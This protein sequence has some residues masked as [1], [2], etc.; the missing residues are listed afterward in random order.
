MNSLVPVPCPAPPRNFV[1]IRSQLFQLSDGETDR[2]PI[3][4]THRTENITSFGGGNNKTYRERFYPCSR[5]VEKVI[6]IIVGPICHDVIESSVGSQSSIGLLLNSRQR[7]TRKRRGKL[8]VHCRRRTYGLSLT[9]SLSLSVCTLCVWECV[10]KNR[11]V[12]AC[13]IPVHCFFPAA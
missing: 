4:Q 1:K 8:T 7:L 10:P 12:C 2:Q 6:A 13:K 3:T 5:S 11:Y 9:R